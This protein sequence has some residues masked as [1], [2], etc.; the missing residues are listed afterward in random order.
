[1]VLISNEE[2]DTDQNAVIR[3]FFCAETHHA[4]P[5]ML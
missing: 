2:G 1:M 4:P 3:F 5:W